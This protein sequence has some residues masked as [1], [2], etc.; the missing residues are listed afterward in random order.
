MIDTTAMADTIR[1]AAQ[2]ASGTDWSTVYTTVAGALIGAMALIASVIYSQ[3]RQTTNLLL[4]QREQLAAMLKAQRSE[5]L[6]ERE[7]EAVQDAYSVVYWLRASL[8]TL[9]MHRVHEE[10]NA[11]QLNMRRHRL[12][13]PE[14]FVC[15]WRQAYVLIVQWATAEQQIQ[16]E[17]GDPDTIASAREL[18]SR[19]V[20]AAL[21]NCQ[22]I[23]LESQGRPTDEIDLPLADSEPTGDRLKKA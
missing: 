18:R 13:L 22:R 16:A 4:A 11:Y 19:A 3:R 23:L 20:P 5:K 17:Q 15:S 14:E 7:L 21:L 2:L 6:L 8:P 9:E 1:V 12:Y 10:V